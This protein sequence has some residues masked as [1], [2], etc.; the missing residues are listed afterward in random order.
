MLTS[1]AGVLWRQLRGRKGISLRTHLVAMVAVLVAVPMVLFWY[2]PYSRALENELDVVQDRHLLIARNL[3]SALQRYY[4]DANA[5]FDFA[6]DALLAGSAMP[7]SRQLLE[8][9][10]FKSVCMIDLATGRIL[11]GHAGTSECPDLVDGTRVEFFRALARENATVVSGV[12]AGRGGEPLV[13]LVRLAGT[14]IVIGAMDT[15]YFVELGRAISFGVKGHAVIVD[16]TGKVLAHPLPAWEAEMRDISKVPVVQRMLAGGQGV[17]TFFSPAFKDDMVTGYTGVPGPGW[18]VMV[19]QPM[20][21][22]RQTAQSIQRSALLVFASGLLIAILAASL[23]A[24]RLVRPL[25]NV[26]QAAR[27][28]ARGERAVR[29]EWSGRFLPRELRMVMASYNVMARRVASFNGVLEQRVAERTAAAERA[30]AETRLANARLTVEVQER[31]RAERDLRESN[32]ALLAATRAKSEFLAAMSHEIRTPMNGVLGLL[33]LLLKTPLDEKQQWYGKTAYKSADSLLVILNDILDYSKLEA[34]RVKL[35]QLSFNLEEK[36]AEVIDIFRPAAEAKSLDISYELPASD[37]RFVVADPTR[38]RQVLM[39]LVGNAVKFTKQGSVK[40]KVRCHE[41]TPSRVRVRIEVQDTGIGIA[42]DAMEKLFTSFTQGDASI[43]RQYG[44]TGLGLSIS[45]QLVEL[46]G[47]RIGGSSQPGEGSTF[48]VELELPRGAAP[49]V[50]ERSVPANAGTASLRVLIAEDNPVNQLV[51]Q[52]TLQQAG[53]TVDLV[54]NGEAA[55][56]AAAK[57]CYDLVLM[58]IQMPDMDGITATRRIRASQSPVWSV[59]IIAVTANVGPDDRQFYLS[60]GMDDVIPK[61]Y[62]AETMHSVIAK[63]LREKAAA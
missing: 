33:E 11:A 4:R 16:H 38:L 37:P 62:K 42:P 7:R 40:L 59:P 45:K 32:A 39:N 53:H 19:P 2:W 54:G 46:M 15:S 3:G 20:S 14:R 27:R 60:V 49:G 47:G 31:S 44:G 17:M 63:V 8:N 41:V 25:D 12:H 29:I 51:A 30:L 36:L 10:R 52:Q 34:G 24:W 1:S 56:T 57:G 23:M 43:S 35:E 13:C 18:G 61:P 50:G 6:A 48:W 28:M 58:D 26:V 22:L 21:E 9:L 55:C 5:T